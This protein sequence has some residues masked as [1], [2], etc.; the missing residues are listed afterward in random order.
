VK[1]IRAIVGATDP[2]LAEVATV[3][4]EFGHDLMVNA[5]HASD[6]QES[7]RR[8]MSIIDFDEDDISPIIDEYFAAGHR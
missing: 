4:R 6:S 2:R 8:E 7:A 1:K 3:R 5:A